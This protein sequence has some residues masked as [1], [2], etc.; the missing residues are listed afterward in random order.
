MGRTI[1]I[2]FKNNK[3]DKVTGS[4]DPRVLAEGR[5]FA[6]LMTERSHTGDEFRKA[7]VEKAAKPA[8]LSPRQFAVL[9][10][11]IEGRPLN[12]GLVGR[13]AAGGLDGTI[14]NLRKRGLLTRDN[15]ITD[16]G[17]AAYRHVE[18]TLDETIPK[19]TLEAT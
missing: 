8:K 4:K 2:R 6:E 12:H 17:I 10:H 3:V 14:V 9:G 7:L 19:E 5:L 11:A 18:T 15:K 16:A 1:S 13:A